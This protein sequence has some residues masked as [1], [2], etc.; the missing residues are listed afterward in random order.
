MKVS[1][2]NFGLGVVVLAMS[3]VLPEAWQQQRAQP[4]SSERA[5][6]Q[7]FPPGSPFALLP[8]FK[9][10]RA[11]VVAQDNEN[12]SFLWIIARRVE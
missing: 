3:V 6:E 2:R 5:Q 8:G 9:I 7:P 4:P 1:F 11:E 12:A 10:E